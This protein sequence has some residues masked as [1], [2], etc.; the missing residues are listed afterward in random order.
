MRPSSTASKSIVALSV[1]ISARI[2][3]EWTSSPSF[4]SHLESL[5]SSMVGDSAGMRICVAIL[6]VDVGVK[7]GRPRLRAF[8]G[9]SRGGVYN[10]ADVLIHH[11]ELV[12]AH[13]SSLHQARAIML[14]GIALLAH[15]LHFLTRAVLRGIA[16]RMPTIAIG[17]Q[18]QDDRA[19]AGA[20]VF[21]G[22]NACGMHGLDIHP[23]H[24]FARDI[25]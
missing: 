21:G 11:L 1:S 19:L 5:P 15:F 18:L 10:A 12:L 13:R 3:P 4:T 14:N 22:V 9:K 8:G 23:I 20:C 2:S 25:E 6:G 24:L 7:F 17:L 16:H